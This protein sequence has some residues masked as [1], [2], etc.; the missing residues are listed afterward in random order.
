MQYAFP[1]PSGPVSYFFEEEW[2]QLYEN[3]PPEHTILLTDEIV[4]AVLPDALQPYRR[5]VMPA[6][7]AS[8]SWETA[9]GLAQ[10]LMQLEAHRKT[11]LLGVGGGVVTDM[12]GLLASVYMRGIAFSFV[13]SSLLGMV[14]AAIGGKNGV[15]HGSHKNMLGTFRQPQFLFYRTE[16]LQTLPDA[17]WSNGFAEIIKYGCTA[18]ARILTMLEEGD[19]AHFQSRPE[20]LSALISG[21]VDVKNKIVNADE[22]ESGLRK[23]LNFGHTAGHAFESLYG[24]PHGSAVGLGMIV[25]ALLSETFCGLSPDTTAVIRRLLQQY[26]LPLRLEFDTDKVLENMRL[27]KKRTAAAV[28]YVLLQKP[29][30]AQVTE[31]SFEQVR[32]GLQRFADETSA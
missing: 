19:V 5:I 23:T 29:G 18:D 7:E 1:F 14:D 27:D 22:T 10:Q 25:A 21:C 13:P 24:L 15:N 6:G 30:V 20:Q 2:R 17:E 28:D 8:K 31:L 12:T 11:G 32:T 9:G 16:L 26:G 4:A 3:A